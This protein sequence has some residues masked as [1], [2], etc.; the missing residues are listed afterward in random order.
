MR[1]NVQTVERNKL[2]FDY[3]LNEPIKM[4]NLKDYFA[5]M[6]SLDP[7]FKGELILIQK[8]IMKRNKAALS[9]LISFMSLNLKNEKNEKLKLLVKK[10]IQALMDNPKGLK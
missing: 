3:W 1:E 7:E 8:K 9:L 6:I 5:F 4:S 2:D 10:L